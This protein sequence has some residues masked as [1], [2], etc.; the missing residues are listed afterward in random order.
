MISESG[1]WRRLVNL[2]ILLKLAARNFYRRSGLTRSGA[3]T[4]TTIL[5][6]V[7]LLILVFS[8]F[9]LLGGLENLQEV[10]EPYIYQFL[11]PGTGEQVSRFLTRMV[12]SASLKSLGLLG[13]V[14]LFA[15]AFSLFFSMENDFNGIWQV[16]K[17]RSLLQR[18]VVYWTMLTLAPLLLGGSLYLTT[19]TLASSQIMHLEHYLFFQFNYALSVLLQ[20]TAFAT[21][22]WIIPNTRVRLYSA[23]SGALV[24]SLL[25]EAAKYG[26]GI[27]TSRA[28][29]YH[30]IYG[31]LAVFPLF[32]LWLFLSWVIILFGAEFTYVVQN[33]R[34]ELHNYRH[35]QHG[36]L[37]PHLLALMI[38]KLIGDAFRRDHEAADYTPEQLAAELS[39]DTRAV[40]RVLYRLRDAG[41]VSFVDGDRNPR[42]LPS[43][44]LAA[45]TVLDIVDP[46]LRLDLSEEMRRSLDQRFQPFFERLTR[47]L[48]QIR[49]LLREVDLWE[50]K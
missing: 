6:L 3:L 2:L 31:S 37:P 44:S 46:F 15:M 10:V 27:Y 17:S 42:V 4:N 18:V 25:W 35:E 26:F 19:R 29:Q 12:E 38:M 40:N 41:L 13:S 32:L 47:P 36:K 8:V 20:F 39:Q 22:Y 21:L 43:R 5:T 45:I 48:Q 11:T 7:P 16:G 28:L 50:E 49:N 9:R 33:R 23:F 30:L 34:V 1:F 24:A 14:V